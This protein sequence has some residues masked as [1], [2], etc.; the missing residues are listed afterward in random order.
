[1]T[2]IPRFIIAI[3]DDAGVN[4]GWEVRE[5]RKT[6][7]GY[8]TLP[9]RPATKSDLLAILTEGQATIAL[10]GAAADTRALA[11]ET[12]LAALRASIAERD[13][14]AEALRVKVAEQAEA[15]AEREQRVTG[16]ERELEAARPYLPAPK[17][18]APA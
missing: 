10:A 15:L 7:H 6:D 16:L 9:G 13:A 18:K 1:M 12:E 14:E 5:E 2:V 17:A 4:T 8:E 3:Q 11:A